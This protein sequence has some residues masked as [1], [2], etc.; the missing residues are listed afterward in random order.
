MMYRQSCKT[1]HMLQNEASVAKI[2][3]GKA[4][5]E[6]QENTKKPRHLKVSDG[7]H[8]CRKE[9]PFGKTSKSALVRG[10]GEASSRSQGLPLSP[11]GD[12]LSLGHH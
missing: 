5:S 6:P 8:D 11:P 3:V 4:E 9:I 10:G 12:L 2:G 7:G 1:Q